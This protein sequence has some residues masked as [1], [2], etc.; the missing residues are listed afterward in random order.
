MNMGILFKLLPLVALGSSSVVARTTPTT[1]RQRTTTTDLLATDLC[2]DVSAE[3]TIPGL[4]GTTIPLGHLGEIGVRIVLAILVD[5]VLADKCYCESQIPLLLTTDPL[6]ISVGSAL[7][8][9]LNDN[10]YM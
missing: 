10:T 8:T 2:G 9:R 4:F 1:L 5:L 6:V 3:F 7:Y